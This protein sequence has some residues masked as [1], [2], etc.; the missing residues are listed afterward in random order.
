MTP[1]S[2]INNK[3]EI[4]EIVYFT[5][6]P[7]IARKFFWNVNLRGEGRFYADKAVQ[8]I[9]CK[10]VYKGMVMDVPAFSYYGTVCPKYKGYTFTHED[11]NVYI[12]E[13]DD[14]EVVRLLTFEAEQVR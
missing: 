9:F 12:I 7:V 8:K 13:D 2:L 1:P 4:G 3:L 11:C 10:S 6:K 5:S 14:V